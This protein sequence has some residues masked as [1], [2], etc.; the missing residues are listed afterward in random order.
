M[1]DDYDESSDD[2]LFNEDFDDNDTTLRAGVHKRVCPD[3]KISLN[4]RVEGRFVVRYCT[5]CGYE[6]ED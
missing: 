1:S 6:T 4:F 3:C 5:Q 2:E